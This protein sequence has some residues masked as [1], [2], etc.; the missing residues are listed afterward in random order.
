M[1]RRILLILLSAALLVSLAGCTLLEKPESKEADK[2]Q[3]RALLDQVAE[4]VKEANA[5]ITAEMAA[6]F[7]SWA[8][9]TEM[10]QKEVT[11]EV[12]DWLS[13]QSPSIRLATEE[14]LNEMMDGLNKILKDGADAAK[15]WDIQSVLNEILASGGIS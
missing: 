15:S 9:S 10:T 13:E 4:N 2:A 1:G 6:D 3:L 12:S 7:V 5:P 14:T 11:Q 8:C